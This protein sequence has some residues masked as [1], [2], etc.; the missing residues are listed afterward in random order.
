MGDRACSLLKAIVMS[1]RAARIVS[2]L[3]PV[4]A[5]SL[6]E[7]TMDEVKKH[8]TKADCW[9][10]IDGKIYDANRD[11]PL[12]GSHSSGQAKFLD[13]HPGGKK[14]VFMR[15]GKDASEAFSEFHNKSIL[16]KYGEA[17]CVGT[18]KA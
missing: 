4:P 18:V 9:I 8:N 16:K 6:P 17:L 3:L 5:A 11:S 13:D 10:V 15:A 14:V 2:H 1:A 12:K 7:F